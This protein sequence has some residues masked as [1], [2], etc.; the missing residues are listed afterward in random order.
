MINIGHRSTAFRRK[1]SPETRPET[2]VPPARFWDVSATIIGMTTAPA[3]MTARTAY[4]HNRTRV[5]YVSRCE[6]R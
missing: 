1:A 6:F 3:V 5:G 2:R 4:P